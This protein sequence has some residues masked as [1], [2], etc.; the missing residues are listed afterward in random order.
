MSKKIY[1][2][3]L[4]FSTTEAALGELF[5]P[6]G[7]LNTI[8]IVNDRLT[9]R[10][11]GFAFVEM[12]TEEDAEAAI[13]ELQGKTLEGR[14]LTVNF[15]R[16]LGSKGEGQTLETRRRSLPERGYDRGDF[17]RRAS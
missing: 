8:H 2:G 17:R 11:K 3:N 5:S 14:V 9:G 13:A 12:V 1:V 10:S 6:Y 7:A 4:P 16:P 15:A